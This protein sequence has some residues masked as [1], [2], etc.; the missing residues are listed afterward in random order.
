MIWQLQDSVNAGAPDGFNEDAFGVEGSTAWVI[1]GA[2]RLGADAS[3][4]D[5]ATV[6][7][8]FAQH[9]SSQ[10]EGLV[11]HERG[12]GMRLDD[13]L[14]EAVDGFVDPE[15]MELPA[16]AAV[17]IV[18]RTSPATV[19]YALLADVYIAVEQAGDS[20]PHVLTDPRMAAISAEADAWID[21]RLESGLSLESARGD[22]EDLLIG[23]RQSRMNQEV[24]DAYWV[25]TPDPD[26]ASHCV[27]GSFEV[28]TVFEGRSGSEGGSGI[29]LAS[30]G[31]AR[32]AVESSLYSWGHLFAAANGRKLSELVEE[33]RKFEME[34]VSPD[35]GFVRLSVHDDATA[36]L[37]S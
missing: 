37:I 22:I 36:I 1:D 18:R 33:L 13:L 4:A 28:P 19:E 11:R 16:S 24:A 9:V 5:T 17:G 26:S 31:F 12:R 25:L 21:A 10:L 29:M 3:G 27:L 34:H 35:S 15:G 30:D 32:L 14:A 2:S 6:A 8:D 20:E 23:Q 7:R